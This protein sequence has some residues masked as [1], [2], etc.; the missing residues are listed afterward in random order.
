MYSSLIVFFWARSVFLSLFAFAL[1]CHLSLLRLL[2]C[3]S[4]QVLDIIYDLVLCPNCETP[5]KTSI[6]ATNTKLSG[7]SS[8][9]VSK[10]LCVCTFSFDGVVNSQESEVHTLNRQALSLR[11]HPGMEDRILLSS[12]R[13]CLVTKVYMRGSTAACTQVSTI[14]D[15]SNSISNCGET[16]RR[17]DGIVD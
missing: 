7:L 5:D 1:L 2:L 13:N 4:C 16:N 14:A 10:S 11:G 17:D 15:V 3:V 6:S 12:E 8:S 9:L